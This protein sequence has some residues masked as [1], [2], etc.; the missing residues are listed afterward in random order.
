MNFYRTIHVATHA[1][2]LEMERLY[3]CGQ[4]YNTI[5]DIV[6]KLVV[7]P[8]IFNGGLAIVISGS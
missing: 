2:H 8:G 7:P 5:L 6:H 4:V 1:Q 3:V